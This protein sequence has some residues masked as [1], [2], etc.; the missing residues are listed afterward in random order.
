MKAA[1][2]E[3]KKVNGRVVL[4][5]SVA[6]YLATK[7]MGPY[8]ASKFAVRAIGASLS[9][10]LEDTGVTCTTVHPGYVES[11]IGQVDNEGNFDPTAKDR[12]PKKL[13][14]S[15]EDAATAIIRAS[16]KRKREVVFTGHG[17]FAVF[18][19]RHLP[20]VARRLG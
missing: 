9:R 7:R 15:S 6:A 10:D 2:P 20:A 13:M 12:R 8:S 1:L 17:K 3:L 4:I 11:Q 16:A 14:W 19:A 5:G 18:M